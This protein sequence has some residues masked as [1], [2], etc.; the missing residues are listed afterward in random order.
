MSPDIVRLACASI[1][2]H[3][4]KYV[5]SIIQHSLMGIFQSQFTIVIFSSWPARLS[6]PTYVHCHQMDNELH[7]S[8][9]FW[10]YKKNLKWNNCFFRQTHLFS[11]LS[12]FNIN[13]NC[14]IKNTDSKLYTCILKV[15]CHVPP[16]TIFWIFRSYDFCKWQ[17]NRK[18]HFSPMQNYFKKNLFA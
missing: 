9:R 10:W 1:Y 15:R 2:V 14:T 18:L 6:W 12:L 7:H 4:Y 17:H 5:H 13:S 16:D 8:K 11:L 3:M